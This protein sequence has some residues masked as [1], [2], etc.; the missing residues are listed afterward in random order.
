VQQEKLAREKD[1]A[2]AIRTEL[3]EFKAKFCAQMKSFDSTKAQIFDELKQVFFI[4]GR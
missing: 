3:V 1:C 2:G 4:V